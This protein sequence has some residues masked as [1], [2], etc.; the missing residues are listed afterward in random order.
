[1]NLPGVKVDLPVITEKDERDLLEFA[2]RQ[3]VDFIAASFV[4]KA[5]D[6]KMIRKTLGPRAR[7]IKII[8]KIENQEGLE[9]YDKI[10]AE[11][12]GIMV[13]RGD[14]GMEIAP[15]KVFLA[16]K[17]MIRKANVMGKPVITATQMLES[18]INNPRPT[19]AECTDVANA[20]LDGSDGV[21]LSV[22]ER[23][24]AGKR[25]RVRGRKL[26]TTY[27]S[28]ASH[29]QGETA[30]GSYPLAAVKM[31]ASVCVE[32]ESCI[33]YSKLYLAVRGSH[34]D[35]FG[36]MWVLRKGERG[37]GKEEKRK[38]KRGKG[39]EERGKVGKG[40]GEEREKREERRGRKLK[41]TDIDAAHALSHALAGAPVGRDNETGRRPR[42][43]HLPQSRRR[44]TWARPR[45]SCSRTRATP[46]GSWQSTGR[47]SRYS[48]SPRRRRRH[49][50][51]SARFAGARARR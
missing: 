16:Q 15:E 26:T 33:D 35:L 19:R 30:S 49:T 8:A 7:S 36:K 2:C 18:M 3:P 10:L 50:R 9:N 42:R 51:S 24:R 43:S 20:V 27:I 39:K 40:G 32:A 25:M 28:R 13:A 22:S 31:M 47:S 46:H 5:S 41:V 11:T 4:T 45:Y 21:M 44:W 37:K 12:D 14:L 29:R 38:R 23:A 1:M 17:M 6:I 48:S 34:L